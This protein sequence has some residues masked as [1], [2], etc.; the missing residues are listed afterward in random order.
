MT[1]GKE[2]ALTKIK[3]RLSTAYH[4]ETDGSTE[5]TNSAVEAYIRA[6]TSYDRKDW[7][8][9]LPLAEL[10]LNGR[11]SA[12]TGV[13]PFFLGHGYHLS[14]LSPTEDQ[15][16]LSEGPGRS[17]IQKGEAIVRTIKEALDWAQ[18]SMVYAQQDMERHSNQR[19]D[20][21]PNYRIS[22][23]VWLSLKNIRTDRP[24]KKLEWNNVKYIVTDVVGTHA[25][26]LNTPPG[27]H[28]VFHVDLLRPA[29]TDP[30]PSQL[31]D[32]T[33]LPAIIVGGE[34]EYMV[35]E[36]LDQRR[37]KRG[38]GTRLE[39]KVKWRGYARPTWEAASALRDTSALDAW[40]N[41]T[42]RVRSPDRQLI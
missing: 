3:R 32:D 37:T 12:A 8:K 20:P 22:D 17:P 16:T 36:I 19:R 14:P 28:P 9:L 38:R 35:E 21:A 27:I 15:D 10:A 25:V 29:S 40:L 7:Y 39:Y 31:S 42:N 33:Q 34:E 30:L 4:P 41:R 18:A 11:T 6:Y 5:R 26:R 2:S 13:S 23:K 24:N 1:C